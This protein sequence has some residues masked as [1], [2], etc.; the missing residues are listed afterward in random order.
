MGD[1]PFLLGGFYSLMLAIAICCAV[2]LVV[3]R[4]V[5]WIERWSKR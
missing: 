5:I 1:G 4:I 3:S 2:G